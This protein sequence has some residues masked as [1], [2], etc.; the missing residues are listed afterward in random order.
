[1]IEIVASIS[2]SRVIGGA[3]PACDVLLVADAPGHPAA[4]W[5][6]D[7]AR[8]CPGLAVVLLVDA[9]GVDTYRAALRIGACAVAT[10]PVSPAGLA[11]AVTDALRAHRSGAGAG[12]GTPGEVIAAAR[13]RGRRRG[14]R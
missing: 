9:A 13:A 5:A 7:A 2:R 12:D 14:R 6:E 10:L 11:A 4:S 3:V 8:A 1:G